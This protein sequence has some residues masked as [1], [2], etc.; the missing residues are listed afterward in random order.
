MRHRS[1]VATIFLFAAVSTLAVGC[2]KPKTIPT[3]PPA[4]TEPAKPAEPVEPARTDVPPEKFP[5]Q[6]VDSQPM[7][8]GADEMNRRLKTVY[9]SYD[10]A[11]FD[12]AALATLRGNADVLKSNPKWKIVVEGNC[13]E[14][15]TI[16][17]NLALGQ[18]RGDSVRQ[19]LASL[20]VPADR[21]RVVSYGEE[22]PAV[23]GHD[24]EAW[25]K[26]RRADFKAEN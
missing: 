9:F 24:E 16:K 21:V 10:S 25:G 22:K 19:Y 8:I 4:T 23:V 13:D 7:D 2:K 11:E 6:P 18:R 26:N 17:Y 12:E 5:T 14:R 1:L 20:G 15:G 3:P